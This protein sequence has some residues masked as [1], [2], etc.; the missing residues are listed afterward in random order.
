MGYRQTM[1]GA[2][3]IRAA[4]AALKTPAELQRRHDVCQ[5][6]RVLQDDGELAIK[7]AIGRII[8]NPE[9]RARIYPFARLGKAV[10]PARR[11][12]NDLAEPLYLVPPVR[13]V[14]PDSEQQRWS[15][16]EKESDVNTVMDDALHMACGLNSSFAQYRFVP[17]L[18]RI[19][20][21]VLLPEAVTVIQ[22]PD[23]PYIPLAVIYDKLVNTSDG[24]KTWRVYW[25][26]Q[27]TFQLDHNGNVVP[28]VAGGPAV[29]KHELG[30]IPILDLHVTP[31]VGGSYWDT[32]TGDD[33]FS[34]QEIASVF[35]ALGARKLK[36][37]GFRGLAVTGDLRT[38]ISDQA[39]DEE[40][41]LKLPEGV[42]L[43]ELTED[44]TATNYQDFIDAVVTAAA[45]SRGISKRRL[46]QDDPGPVRKE[47]GL[48]EKRA[49][50]VKYVLKGEQKQFEILRAL[51]REYPEAE[52]RLSLDATMSVDFGEVEARVDPKEELD[53]W[54][55]RIRA[56]TANRLDQIRA[57]NP[58]VRTDADA[59]REFQRNLEI[60]AEEIRRV[61][62]LNIPADADLQSP[63][64]TPSANGAMGSKV[65]DKEMT[66][67][68]AA[69]AATGNTT[70][71]EE[72]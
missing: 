26:D 37:R 13:T 25:D 66:R 63:G 29:T 54:E 32:T 60:R 38:M 33:L 53:L 69:Q 49:R 27:E 44:A 10:T 41:P 43:T 67:D 40:I 47:E 46:N 39:L 56:G 58:E 59:W 42:T 71:N 6:R 11:I 72:E 35:T 21:G 64:Q 50:L 55:A 20:A 19:V 24:P 23:D 28:Y 7:A 16:I 48:A 45:A 31:R 36:N 8:T 70:T 57:E 61:R 22:D 4:K 18:N 68:E 9:V 65:R 34:A 12:V 51:S 5:R 15:A 30:L 14:R 17:R 1:G 3:P 52:R 62:A 2:D